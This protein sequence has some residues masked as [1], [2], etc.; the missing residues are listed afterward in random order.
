MARDA[1]AGGSGSELDLLGALT[2]AVSDAHTLRSVYDRALDA[3][4]STLGME[5]AA[6][7]LFDPDGVMRFK[8]WRNLSDGYRE[9]VEG[10]NPWSPEDPDPRPVVVHDALATPDLV[11]LHPVLAREGIG[12][13]A[14]VPLRH[15]SALLGKFMV[16]SPVANG[17]SERDVRL[18]EAIARQVATAIEHKRHERRLATQYSVARAVAEARTVQ[19]GLERVLGDLCEL[20]E[21]RFAAVWVVNERIGEIRCVQ[22]WMAPDGGLEDFD[23]V[24]RSMPMTSG[25]GLPGR[26]WATGRPAWIRDAPE[27]EN[28]PRARWAAKAG[29]HAACGFP[30]Q[31]DGRVVAAME[32]FS[33]DIRPPDEDLLLLMAA[34]GSQIGQFVERKQGEIAL[35]Q[36]E[37]LKGAIL[38]SALDAVITMDADGVVVDV[39]DVALEIFGRRREEMVGSELAGLV[40]PPGLRERHRRGLRRYVETGEGAIVGHRV[41]LT[42][43][44]RDGTEFPVELAVTRADVVGSPMFVGY[45]RDIT[46]RAKA[47]ERLRFLVRATDVLSSSLDPEETLGRIA[48]LAVPVLADWCVTYLLTPAGSIRRLGVR[49]ADPTKE[50]IARRIVDAFPIDPDA[51]RGVSRVIASGEPLLDPDTGADTMAAVVEDR[52]GLRALIEP[53]DVTS[54]MCVPLTSRGAVIGAVAFIAS[55]SPRRFGPNDVE[56]AVELARRAGLAL[57]NGR[58]YQERDTIARTLQE[59]LLPPE[60]PTIPAIDVAAAYLPGEGE[61]GGDFYDVF[62]TGS[63]TWGVVIG[64]VCGKG[65]E[66]AAVMAQARYTVRAAAMRERGPAGI[67][68]TVNEALV[69]AGRDRFLTAAHLQLRLGSTVRAR[70]SVGGHPPPLLVRTDGTIRELG[71]PGMLLGVFPGPDLFEETQ[72]LEPGDSIVMFTDGVPDE[73]A[74]N[75]GPDP[76]FRGLLRDHAGRTAGEIVEAIRRMV[77]DRTADRP[78]DD[79]AVVVVRVRR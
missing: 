12:S 31:V 24:T 1:R 77:Q 22:T 14:F 25:V 74:S 26:V 33:H 40:I 43:M 11:A 72:T 16:Y 23:E 28:F 50:A 57:D 61:V 37:A 21:W 48:D 65:A 52:E 36:S 18:A 70:V 56:I 68:R 17:L 8:A 58:L 62:Q 79:A 53:L 20:L 19:D 54:W 29:L 49:H 69:R 55:G 30:I 66:A 5:R 67:L 34:V 71:I 3:L 60:L 46:E 39:N 73:R 63:S 13:L 6:I 7:L 78:A 15:G 64:D 51:G 38:R 76:R 10:H 45:L 32:F 59:S 27:D 42:A 47:E 9:A 44:R 2:E 35:R 4:T 75:G 41:E